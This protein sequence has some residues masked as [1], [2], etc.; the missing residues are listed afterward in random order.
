MSRSLESRS[1]IT[2]SSMSISPPLIGSSPASMRSSVDL[3]QPE[4]PTSTTNSPSA[5]SKLMP[6]MILNLPKFFSTPRKDTDAMRTLSGSALHGA[7]GEAADH[8]AL[9]GVV[10]RRRRQRVDQAGRHHQFPWRIVGRK[11]AAQRNAERGAAV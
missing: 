6:W 3:P 9:E 1:L 11:E 7:G 5:M 4:G 8:V 2:R 10:D